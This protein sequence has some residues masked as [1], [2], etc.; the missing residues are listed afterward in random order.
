M[1][2]RGQTKSN[3]SSLVSKGMI[4]SNNLSNNNLTKKSFNTNLINV[5]H[6]RKH[7]DEAANSILNFPQD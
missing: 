5:K 2:Q 6:K 7:K 3:N 4:K 1:K